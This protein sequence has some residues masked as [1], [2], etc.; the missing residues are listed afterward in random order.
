MPNPID[1][2]QQIIEAALMVSGKPLTIPQL[3]NLF[4]EAEQPSTAEIRA[5]LQAL[6]EHYALHSGVELH[7]VASG[8]QFQ[9][10]KEYSSW[11]A[12]LWEEKPARYSRALLE[13]LA[14]IA[15]RQPIT[16]AEIEEIRGVTVSSHITKTLLERE[17][18]KVIG[19]REV[20]GKPALYGTTKAFLDHFNLKNLAE[21]PT[22]AEL[23]DLE[24]QEANLQVQLE[25]AN[26]DSEPSLIEEAATSNE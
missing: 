25:L 17:W 12:K 3:Q 19:Y 11:L 10:R 4:E 22:L 26:T 9:A 18:I 8:F 21:L 20:P 7:E 6:S 15:Y 23:K 16:R 24:H 2:L 5:C 1:S 14:L 13:T